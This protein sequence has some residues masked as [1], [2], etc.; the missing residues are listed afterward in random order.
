MSGRD[1]K[2]DNLGVYKDGSKYCFSCAYKEDGNTLNLERLAGKIVSNMKKKAEGKI[3]LPEDF[4]R[5]L[6]YEAI[7]WLRLYGITDAEIDANEIGWSPSRSRL[8]FPIR[9]GQDQLLMWQGRLFPIESA[10]PGRPKVYTEGFKERVYHILGDIGVDSLCL[11]E[12][13]ISAIKISRTMPAM[14]IWGSVISTKRILTLETMYNSLFIWLDGDM[15]EYAA[16]RAVYARQF[17]KG[18][19][20]VVTSHF[21]PKCYND[22]EVSSFVLPQTNSH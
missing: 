11:V 3:C 1:T 2:G 14:P 13:I 20:K 17:F 16:E 9:G 10:G 22:A 8:I 6:P 12:D 21:D 4:T 7:D 18:P 19:V 5:G 15:K